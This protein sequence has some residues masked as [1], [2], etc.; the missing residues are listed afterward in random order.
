MNAGPTSERVQHSLRRLIMERGYR[1]GSRLDPAE[2]SAILASSTTPIRE[3]L[4]HLAGEGLV[5]ARSGG[6]FL[7]PLIDEPGLKDLY[8]WSGD[9]VQLALRSARLSL[10]RSIELD[11]D[12]ASGADRAAHLLHRIASAS[13]NREHGEAMERTNARLHVAR[14]GEE[15]ILGDTG[16][17]LQ[18]LAHSARAGDIGL[19]RRTSSTYHLRR[20]RAAAKLLRGIYRDE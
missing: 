6:G 18:A 2:L 12:S 19:L 3:A 13:S 20:Q 16:E 15:D 11:P 7:V 9:I 1:P 17:E 10:L 14:I 8:A 4:S 5:E